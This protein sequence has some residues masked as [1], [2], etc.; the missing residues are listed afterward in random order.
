[1]AVEIRQLKDKGTDE[2]FVPVTHWDAVSNK[3]DIATK[4][5]V[6]SLLP[7]ILAAL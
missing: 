2:P 5:D 4:S 7:L 1:M 6:N 3:P